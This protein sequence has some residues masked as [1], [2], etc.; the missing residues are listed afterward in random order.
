MIFRGEAVLYDGII[1]LVGSDP[2]TYYINAFD[3]ATETMIDTAPFIM[4]V[5][6]AA[7]GTAILDGYLYIFGGE[8]YSNDYYYTDSVQ[9]CQ[10]SGS[11]LYIRLLINIMH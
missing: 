2:Y 10:L 4:P 5:R 6:T 7:M 9:I 1:Y 3:V 11:S 8:A